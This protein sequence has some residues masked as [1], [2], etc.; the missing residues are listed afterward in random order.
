VSRASLAA[1]AACLVGACA[2]PTPVPVPEPVVVTPID[3]C[4]DARVRLAAEPTLMVDRS[5]VPV[6]T[7]PPAFQRIPRVAL[8]QDGSADVKVDVV[9]DTLGRADMKTFTVVSVSHAWFVGDLRRVLP[10]WRFTPAEMGGCKVPGIYHFA[11]G[12][13]PRPTP[14]K[15]SSRKP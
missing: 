3:A 15:A 10:Q 13:R 14:V 5:P 11:G 2:K 12:I 1:I 9:I 8:R 7:K 6:S 4:A